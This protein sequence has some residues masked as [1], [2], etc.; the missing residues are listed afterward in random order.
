[1]TDDQI[2]MRPANENPW[3]VLAT[4]YGEQTGDRIDED[5]HAKNREIWNRWMAAALSDEV[6]QKL[7]DEKRATVAEMKPFSAEERWKVWA[8]CRSPD[9][10]APDPATD[11]NFN[12]TVFASPVSF[13]NFFFPK[14][15]NFS[16]SEF[17]KN[18]C[19]NL[20]TFRD[21]ADFQHVKFH[22]RSDF[23]SA[24]FQFETHFPFAKFL[25]SINFHQATFQG[26]ASFAD[27][28]FSGQVAFNEAAF[29]DFVIFSH[30]R[31]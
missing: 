12:D 18:T 15:T 14:T 8:Y 22:G 10:F 16:Q 24:T 21:H 30:A 27:T 6:R 4:Y 9:L 20:T 28:E 25:Q 3:Y 29:L 31:P 1:M 11:I 5:L 2:E 19:F 23:R 17:Q 13:D 7:I 26:N